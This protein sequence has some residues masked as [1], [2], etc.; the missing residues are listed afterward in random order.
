VLMYRKKSFP[1]DLAYGAH[2]VS[3]GRI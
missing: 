3:L 1:Y 2:N